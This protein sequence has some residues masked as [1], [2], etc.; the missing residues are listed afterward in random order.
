MEPD[1]PIGPLRIQLPELSTAADGTPVKNDHVKVL[2]ADSTTDGIT[3]QSSFE[4]LAECQRNDEDVP[5]QQQPATKEAAQPA[6]SNKGKQQCQEDQLQ[7]DVDEQ[8]GL[9]CMSAQP[10]G[11]RYTPDPAHGLQELA[12][13]VSTLTGCMFTTGE[14]AKSKRSPAVWWAICCML[15]GCGSC[16]CAM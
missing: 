14:A 8:Q 2:H 13:D 16:Q 7:V 3:L 10:S 1:A 12:V 5:Q 15:L 6:T 9:L 11:S 4:G